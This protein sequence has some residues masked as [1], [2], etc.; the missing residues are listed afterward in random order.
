MHTCV[1][2]HALVL[3][4]T[5]VMTSLLVSCNSLF[6]AGFL[7]NSCEKNVYKQFGSPTAR[8]L[9]LQARAGLCLQRVSVY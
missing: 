2:T 4:K 1:C 3:S 7:N 6:L 9:L 5:V 8:C